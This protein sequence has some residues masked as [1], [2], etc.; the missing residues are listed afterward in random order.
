V[1]V[2]LGFP[3]WGNDPVRARNWGW[4]REYVP[5]LY[6]F[7]RVYVASGSFPHTRGG[8]RNDLIEM[9]AQEDMDVAVLCD[10]DTFC[11]TRA[12]HRA[13]EGAYTAGGLHFPYNK[14]RILTREGTEDLLT[15][16]PNWDTWLHSSGP[17]SLGGVVVM[18]PSDWKRAGGSPEYTGWGFE[19]VM[20]AVQAR[21]FLRENTWYEG[22]VTCLYHQTECE[23]G[24]PE[25]VRNIGYCQKVEGLD[26][27][28]PALWRHIRESGL[29]RWTDGT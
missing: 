25:Y 2:G 22:W 12:L 15:G 13:I 17:G 1:K 7:T 4:V 26:R 29:W 8:A 24:T 18:S 28:A 19:D 3:Y 16:L 27:D 9:M 23:M 6:P 11:D 21:T 20:F 5:T 10:A 14:F